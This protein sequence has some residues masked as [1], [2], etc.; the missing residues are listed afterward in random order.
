MKVGATRDG[1]VR[2]ADDGAL[3]L[4]DL[5]QRDLCSLL[6]AS[7]DWREHVTEASVLR[8][9]APED[10]VGASIT[11]GGSSV[12]GIGLNYESRVLS[13]GR[14]PAG[15]SRGLSPLVGHGRPTG[16]GGQVAGDI[17]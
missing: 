14:T 1:L 15:V 16:R 2:G 13:T 12:W 10:A 3:E 9:L 17:V 5:P 4:L 8:R 7:N 6:A 11:D